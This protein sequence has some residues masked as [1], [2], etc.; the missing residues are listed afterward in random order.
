MSGALNLMPRYH[1]DAIVAEEIGAIVIGKKRGDRWVENV[2]AARICSRMRAVGHAS[3]RKRSK[4]ATPV[5]RVPSPVLS[6]GGGRLFQIAPRDYL[7]DD[8]R[9]LH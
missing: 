9:S 6:D 1:M 5:V 3:D 2:E 8:E 7:A 4:D